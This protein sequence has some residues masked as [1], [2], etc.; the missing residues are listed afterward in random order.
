MT[1]G[2][3]GGSVSDESTPAAGAE[4]KPSH[5]HGA[6]AAA[7]CNNTKVNHT[8]QDPPREEGGPS[9]WRIAARLIAVVLCGLLG[10]VSGVVI[11]HWTRLQ[12]AGLLW[13]H[14]DS[15]WDLA[16]VPQILS[17]AAATAVAGAWVG[18]WALSL[19]TIPEMKPQAAELG[20]SD[21][22]V[23]LRG[24]WWRIPFAGLSAFLLLPAAIQLVLLL[25]VK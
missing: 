19:W 17:G 15:G 5:P 24:L 20:Q 6:P 2:R 9:G 11:G 23:P 12:V 3:T 10:G 7:Y 14:Y 22:K 18:W 25:G 8:S 13:P 1:I 4:D 16:A 21:V